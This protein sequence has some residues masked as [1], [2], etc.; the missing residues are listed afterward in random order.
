MKERETVTG[1]KGL[2]DLLDLSLDR[3]CHLANSGL[4]DSATIVCGAK[5]RLFNAPLVLEL[6]T[7]TNLEAKSEGGTNGSK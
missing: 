2:A 7:K 4:I 5:K 6:L 1:L 3:A